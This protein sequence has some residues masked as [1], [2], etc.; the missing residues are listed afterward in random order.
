MPHGMSRSPGEAR[1]AVEGGGYLT[2]HVNFLFPH[3][4]MVFN[5]FL[6]LGASIGSASPSCGI[7]RAAGVRLA[8]RQAWTSFGK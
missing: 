4:R 2:S 8:C 1:R 5:F 7:E 6:L 3:V